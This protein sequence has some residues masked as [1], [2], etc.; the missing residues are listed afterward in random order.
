MDKQP[1]KIHINSQK[2]S[3]EINGQ[4]IPHLTNITIE[5]RAGDIPKLHLEF[6]PLDGIEVDGWATVDALAL[7]PSCGETASVAH[8]NLTACKQAGL[9]PR[10]VS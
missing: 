7:C 1:I 8:A 10:V 4:R 3:V 2:S 9:R 6:L 5:H